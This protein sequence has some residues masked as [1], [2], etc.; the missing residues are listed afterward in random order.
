M[1]TGVNLLLIEYL[2]RIMN[3]AFAK[4]LVKNRGMSSEFNHDQD[5]FSFGCFQV[6]EI[7]KSVSIQLTA[8]IIIYRS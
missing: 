3:A 4:S 8:A 5:C 6:Q 7:R 1:A 2:P